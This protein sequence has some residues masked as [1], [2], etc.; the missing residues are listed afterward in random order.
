MERETSGDFGSG[1]KEG[2]G[3]REWKNMS[4]PMVESVKPVSMFV[5]GLT[6]NHHFLL[7]VEMTNQIN[8]L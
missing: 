5:I 7:G 2:G 1:I 6:K 4:V 3:K 8:M